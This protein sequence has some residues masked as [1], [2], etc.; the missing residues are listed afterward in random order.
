MK[1]WVPLVR[2]FGIAGSALALL[3][4]A[5]PLQSQHANTRTGIALA[6]ASYPSN[7]MTGQTVFAKLLEHNRLREARLQQYSV[8]RT[9]Q[10]KSSSGKVRAE[11][12]V[13]MQYRAP[14]VKEFKVLSEGGSGIIRG[15]VFKPLMDSEVET[16]AGRS[17]SDSSINPANYNFEVIGE[18]SV[19][20]H[21]CIV[22]QATPTR[23][24][25]Y[26]F[27]GKVWIHATEFAVVRIEGQPAR[28]PSWWIKQVD[29][30]RRYQKIGQFWLPAQDESTSQVRVF[31]TYTLTVSHYSYE[32]QK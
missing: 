18:E 19:D 17:R 8:T 2:R 16:A 7:G 5:I 13:L 31:G 25:K 20:G 3:L 23:D 15:R 30:V 11:T 22:V 27:K 24:D 6:L 21:Q 32:M 4:G 29:F 28:T 10:I 26:L 14:G 1:Q 12:Q 9:Y